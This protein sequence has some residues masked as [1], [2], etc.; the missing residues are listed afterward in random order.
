MYCEYRDGGH[1]K[2]YGDDKNYQETDKDVKDRCDTDKY[3]DDDSDKCYED[4][5]DLQC[6]AS[7]C[8][9]TVDKSSDGE[10]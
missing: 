10:R 1:H 6:K 7:S 8:Q 2:T 3:T 4:F 5:M 9:G